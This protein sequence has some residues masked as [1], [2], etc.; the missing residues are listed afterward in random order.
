MS[1]KW[2]NTSGSV[3]CSFITTHH[4]QCFE[5]TYIKSQYLVLLLNLIFGYLCLVSQYKSSGNIMHSL[6][7]PHNERDS[8]YIIFTYKT[9]LY[10]SFNGINTKL[11]YTNFN[12]LLSQI[13]FLNL[14]GGKVLIFVLVPLSYI[15]NINLKIRNTH[16]WV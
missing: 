9:Q 3:L 10:T 13:C 11:C 6:S 7:V 4:L 2:Y 15:A 5:I 1:S 14:Q 12:I 16:Q 8:I